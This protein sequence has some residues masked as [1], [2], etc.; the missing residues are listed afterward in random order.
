M[1]A[2]PAHP[3]NEWVE[4]RTEEPVVTVRLCRAAPPALHNSSLH[5]CATLGGWA[6]VRDS[7]AGRD[8]YSRDLSI[9]RRGNTCPC[10]KF[11]TPRLQNRRGYKINTSRAAAS[12]WRLCGT[13]LR[14]ITGYQ[15]TLYQGTIAQVR[16]DGNPETD[17]IPSCAVI[18]IDV[19]IS[20]LD[21][22]L[23]CEAVASLL[24]TAFLCLSGSRSVKVSAVDG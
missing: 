24:P 13:V 17:G 22:I 4:P 15:N 5:H 6:D 7:F 14:F 12:R 3:Q 2:L 20:H 23:T 16:R 8:V 21:R 10:R 11:N 9:W 18:D 1:P 19:A